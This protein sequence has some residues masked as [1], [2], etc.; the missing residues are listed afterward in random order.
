MSILEIFASSQIGR[1]K[2][3]KLQRTWQ[4]FVFILVLAIF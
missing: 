4:I 2:K 1:D 3:G